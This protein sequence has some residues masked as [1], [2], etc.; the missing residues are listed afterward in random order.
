DLADRIHFDESR[1]PPPN[2]SIMGYCTLRMPV[3]NAWIGLYFIRKDEEQGLRL[4]FNRGE[5]G[6]IFYNQLLA[7]KEVIDQELPIG[8]EWQSED[9]KHSIWLKR[10][11]PGS[12][13]ESNKEDAFSWFQKN[14]NMFVNAFRPRLARYKREL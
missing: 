6:D 14:A 12:L 3:T 2:P 1:Q 10:Q 7:E 11:L 4:T 5:L 9:G 8:T 13:N